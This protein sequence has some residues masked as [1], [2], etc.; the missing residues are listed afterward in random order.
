MG[1]QEVCV[2]CFLS[3]LTTSQLSHYLWKWLLNVRNPKPY[4]GTSGGCATEL[5]EVIQYYHIL[6]SKMGLL[7]YP[8]PPSSHQGCRETPHTINHGGG[9][10]RGRTLYNPQ[11]H[12]P[13]IHVLQLLFWFTCVL[14]RFTCVLLKVN[15]P[16]LAEAPSWH[17]KVLSSDGIGNGP[18]VAFQLFLFPFP[19]IHLSARFNILPV[20]VCHYWGGHIQ[21][22]YVVAATLCVCVCVCV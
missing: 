15:L 22:L 12:F 1:R 4:Q 17:N 14:L 2:G 21:W 6:H 5:L 3:G 20:S 7:L 13:L 8:W 18:S 19:D 9:R 11:W 10:G 16:P